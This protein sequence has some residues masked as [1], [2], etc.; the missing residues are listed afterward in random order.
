MFDALESQASQTVS[1]TTQGTVFDTVS[2]T[3]RR[4]LKAIFDVQAFSSATAGTTLV[5]QVFGS[6]DNTTFYLVGQSD[7]F[8]STTAAQGKELYV[9]FETPHRYLRLDVNL[10]GGATPT[11][12]YRAQL[13]LARPV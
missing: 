11:L 13:A 12:T 5:G 3:P 8:V 7:P 4:G 9:G 10:A 2:G 1:A 6:D